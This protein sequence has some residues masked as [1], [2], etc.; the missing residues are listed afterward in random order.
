MFHQDYQTDSNCIT[1]ATNLLNT[2]NAE[3]TG[4]DAILNLP[5][6]VDYHAPNQFT[7][8][9]TP[10]YAIIISIPE[11]NPNMVSEQTW[12]STGME[13]EV[14]AN[15]SINGRLMPHI[16]PTYILEYDV[17]KVRDFCNRMHKKYL[18]KV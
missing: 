11:L 13:I 16:E 7:I 1:L 15:I 8:S 9:I 18:A 4:S 3:N 17:R 10:C 12:Q 6:I 5:Q 14:Y 2:L